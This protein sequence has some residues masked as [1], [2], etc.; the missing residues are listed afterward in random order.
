MF[1]LALLM[2]IA[3][4]MIGPAITSWAH[5]RSGW[6]RAIDAA[7]LGIVLP[8]LLLRLV[9]HI[10]DEIGASAIAAVA[11]GYVAFSALE[12]RTHARATQLGAAI[13]LPTLGIHAFLDG[14]ALAIAF[15][16]GGTD[17]AGATL[18]A[19]LILHRVPEGLVI[20]TALVP[21]LG[22]RATMYRVAALAL[23]TLMGGV[24]G[25]ELLAH[26][27]DRAL[28]VVVAVGLG[29]MLR[30]IVHSHHHEHADHGPR[31][32]WLDGLV[33]V[34]ALAIS[35]AV[36][37][38]WQL[39]EQSQPHELSA[40]QAVVPLFLETAPWILATLVIAQLADRFV[41]AHHAD[42]SWASG[43][44]A[45][46]ILATFWLGPWFAAAVALL[47]PAAVW[48]SSHQ[49]T[50]LGSAIPRASLILP[51]Y[52]AGIAIAI[53]AEAAVPA[54]AL[55]AIGWVALPIAA[56]AACLAPMSAAGLVPIA[57]IL[58]HKGFL[59]GVGLAFVLVGVVVAAHARRGAIRWRFPATILAGTA[60]AVAI[61]P[62]LESI[63]RLH[64]LGRHEHAWFEYA[65]ASA[66]AAWI[67]FELVRRGPRPFFE[68]IR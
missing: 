67:V 56:A 19:A 50:T 40:A 9:P 32:E 17:A 68:A 1:G 11:V 66:V 45:A 20:A 3:G 52:A 55:G 59:P 18:G 58:V 64:E 16:H 61:D 12:A 13:L 39:F 65:A 48:W 28:H 23:M 54:D 31:R 57:A 38:P 4:L 14:T 22:V 44:L 62:L 47:G 8:L 51:S 35:F 42:R 10:V 49:R 29:V 60:I 6:L 46:A 41:A 37:A 2:S 5:G 30:M 7:M 26:T 36:P 24:I 15:Q 63:P 27:P 34:G 43:W 25:R 53:T 33:F 21:T